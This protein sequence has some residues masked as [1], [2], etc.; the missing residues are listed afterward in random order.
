MLTITTMI[1]AIS[2]RAPQKQNYGNYFDQS[3]QTQTAL[4]TNQS[5]KQRHVTDAKRGKTRASEARL[6]LVFVA[7]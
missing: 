1:S 7:H 3:T 5:S 2:K 4:W 6:A